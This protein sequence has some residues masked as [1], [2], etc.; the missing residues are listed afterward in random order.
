MPSKDSRLLE[1]LSLLDRV[2][3]VDYNLD[4]EFRSFL[5]QAS[6]HPSH[7]RQRFLRNV[8]SIHLLFFA[9]TK[10]L[11]KDFVSGGTL[12]TK[13]PLIAPKCAGSHPVI[14]HI[15]KNGCAIR[16]IDAKVRFPSVFL[17]RV[18]NP[19]PFL[20]S[21]TYFPCPLGYFP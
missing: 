19:W 18:R 20:E 2:S 15:P 10:K 11:S 3:V 12:G 1:L 14:R 4:V 7:A 17:R 5:C 8:D 13:V 21:R 16:D 6:Q 9:S